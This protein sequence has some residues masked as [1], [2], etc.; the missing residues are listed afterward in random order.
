[1]GGFSL[2]SKTAEAKFFFLNGNTRPYIGCGV[3]LFTEIF[4]S[5]PFPK[6]IEN[7]WVLEPKIGVLLDS[8]VLKNLFV[9][10]SVSYLRDDL[11]HRGPNAFNL[12]I[13]L[14]YL[15]DRRKA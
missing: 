5:S 10:A 13:G 9:D 1:M 7:S 15:I 12:A 14:K 11:T 4:D 3:G 6:Q 2:N 8:K